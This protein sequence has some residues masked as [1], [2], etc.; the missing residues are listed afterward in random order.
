MGTAACCG[1]RPCRFDCISHYVCFFGLL[2]FFLNGI[3]GGG[4]GGGLGGDGI[5]AGGVFGCGGFGEGGCFGS[6]LMGL[7][8]C[9]MYVE[10]M[11]V[12]VTP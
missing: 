5:G 2:S 4:L 6:L 12:D 3:L 7:N 1:R 10:R 11:K 9:F 8:F